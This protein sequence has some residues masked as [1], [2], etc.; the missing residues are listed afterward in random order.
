VCA[1]DGCAYG[2]ARKLKGDGRHLVPRYEP[3]VCG[4]R[5]RSKRQRLG[6]ASLEAME[7]V[8]DGGRGAV[9]STV[10]W[11]AV[12]FPIVLTVS[13]WLLGST[14]P[15]I[16]IFVISVGVWLWRWRAV[17]QDACKMGQ[18]RII[19]LGSRYRPGRSPDW[20]TAP[21]SVTSG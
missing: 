1:G 6:S 12:S 4:E 15:G 20:L 10:L 19:S 9:K 17:F 7:G 11:T 5:C 16:L 8:G 21:E 14:I 13:W 18:E 3:T 2:E